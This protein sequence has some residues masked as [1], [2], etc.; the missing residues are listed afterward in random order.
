MK[1]IILGSNSPRRRAFLEELGLDFRLAERYEV[2]ESVDSTIAIESVAA[3]LSERK[4]FGYKGTISDDEVL[5]TAD[6]VVIVD[7]RVLGKPHDRAEAIEMLTSLSAKT[8]RVIT[9]FTL[10]TTTGISTTSVT[11]G[12]TFRALSTSEIEWYVDNFSPLDKAGAYGIQEWVGTAAITSLSGSYHNVVGL[13]TAHLLEAL[14]A[15]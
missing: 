4:S 3:N 5:L 8:H 11:T 2:D 7:N 10:R 9:A 15:L 6:T 12:V 13:P 1:R 14:R